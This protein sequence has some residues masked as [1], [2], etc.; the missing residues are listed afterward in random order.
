MKAND[1]KEMFWT[2][3]R[4]ERD[5]MMFWPLSRNPI[6]MKKGSKAE[7]SD[8][9][10]AKLM[11]RGLVEYKGG[12]TFELTKDGQAMQEWLKQH[13]NETSGTPIIELPAALTKGGGESGFTLDQLRA[14]LATCVSTD[15]L[16][17]AL[18]GVL[19]MPD[20]LVATNSY[21]LVHVAHETGE[22]IDRVAE[23]H[24]GADIPA[25]YPG[26]RS[27]LVDHQEGCSGHFRVDVQTL[28]KMTTMVCKA[29]SILSQYGPD[30][31]P[32]IAI[33][34]PVVNPFV[35]KRLMT[36]FDRLG[37]TTVEVRAGSATQATSWHATSKYGDP[38]RGLV[39]PV[40]FEDNSAKAP[41]H[42]EDL[43]GTVSLDRV[44][45]KAA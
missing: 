13:L 38:V 31:G 39:M 1:F 20:G 24:T 22:E 5:A 32:V 2:M 29:H 34:D 9:T 42:I 33:G 8:V 12:S 30:G 37:C 10:K 14:A 16:R 28:L 43:R 36:S 4:G 40:R 19:I 6:G 27:V 3:T 7:I 11:R 25:K 21:V 15:E 26:W 18:T 45:A 23:V 17:P 35:L 44:E 41:Y